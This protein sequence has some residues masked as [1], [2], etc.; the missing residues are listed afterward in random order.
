MRS[1]SR[2]DELET[3]RDKQGQLHFY[4]AYPELNSTH[5]FRWRQASNP[6]SITQES[7][8]IEG[9]EIVNE[10]TDW[11]HPHADWDKFVGLRS[12]S[13]SYRVA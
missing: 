3:L 6:L 4:R 1:I 12:D 13:R 11:I 2:L 8:E 5:G 10:D 9:F 7:Q